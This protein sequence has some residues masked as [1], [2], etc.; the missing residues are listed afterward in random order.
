VTPNPAP[1]CG[2]GARGAPRPSGGAR[3]HRPMFGL[4]HC[5]G[6]HVVSW[7]GGGSGVGVARGT[8]REIPSVPDAQS[9][10]S[11]QRKDR[12]PAEKL[13]RPVPSSW[14][15][16]CGVRSA[17]STDPQPSRQSNLSDLRSHVPRGPTAPQDPCRAAGISTPMAACIPSRFPSVLRLDRRAN[18]CR[19]RDA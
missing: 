1:T 7:A 15:T 6:L 4:R 16:R 14:R 13:A 2:P 12:P 9:L 5:L 19:K 11:P 18:G 17:A 10:R 3:A 8:N